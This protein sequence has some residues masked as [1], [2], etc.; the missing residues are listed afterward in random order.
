MII[1]MIITVTGDLL[2]VVS[3]C[4]GLWEHFALAGLKA[5]LPGRTDGG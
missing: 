1:I 5:A 4:W 2:R 3:V